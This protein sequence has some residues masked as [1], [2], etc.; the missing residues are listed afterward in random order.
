M[1]KPRTAA[2]LALFATLTLSACDGGNDPADPM[3]T[4]TPSGTVETPSTTAP[5]VDPLTVAPEGETARQFIRR[6]VTLGNRMQETGETKAFLALAGPD[7][8][9]CRD[10]AA[11][12]DEIYANSGSITSAG[13]KVIAAKHD[14]GDQ[15]T[16][17]LEGA[18]TKYVE[19][20]GA[21]EETLPG[22][23]YELVL[24]IVE[25]DGAWIVGEYEDKR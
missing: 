22:G 12:I 9:S 20:K 16:V 17:T 6:W 14:G 5:T 21:E 10:Y 11:Q 2:S 19:S 13:S 8:K 3:S 25:V 15:W 4:W 1:R 23:R 18:P 7:C 24:Y